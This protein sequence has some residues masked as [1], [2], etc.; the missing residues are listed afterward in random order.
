MEVLGGLAYGGHWASKREP[1]QGGAVPL[2]KSQMPSPVLGELDS[3]CEVQ[4]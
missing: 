1:Q 3:I 2:H 4:I